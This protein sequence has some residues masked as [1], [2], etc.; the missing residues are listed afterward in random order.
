ML[1]YA[2][3][4]IATHS[5]TITMINILCTRDI[6]DR[7]VQHAASEN[8][9][10]DIVPFIQVRPAIHQNDIPAI[11]ALWQ[12]DNAVV[13]FTSKHAVHALAD[14][15]AQQKDLTH[16][17]KWNIYCISAV[18][19]QSARERFPHATV[20]GNSSYAAGLAENIL[21]AEN[22][23]DVWF[24][25]GNK[26]RDVLPDTLQNNGIHVN[27]I[28]V[29]DTILTSHE[30]SKAYDGVVFFSPSAVESFFAVN[31][32]NGHIPCFAIGKTTAGA[33]REQVSNEVMCSAA[34]DAEMMIQ[35][36]IDFFT[37]SRSYH[38]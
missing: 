6:P 14:F 19:L 13:I 23:N 1:T 15:S 7:L 8:I 9:M 16:S 27:E 10:L 18:T 32:I 2:L 28:T 5:K 33:I 21:Q 30:L 11:K 4:L 24:F 3:R 22:I 12:D 20:N 29:Y 17:P 37:K 34:Q 25:C 31:Q 35:T 36:V 38:A 26:R